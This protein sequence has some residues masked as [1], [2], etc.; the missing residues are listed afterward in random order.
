[1]QVCS[2]QFRPA[3]GFSGWQI[4]PDCRD[5]TRLAGQSANTAEK[6]QSFMQLQ[7]VHLK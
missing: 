3:D 4:F 2:A 6:F 7:F 5:G 1:M